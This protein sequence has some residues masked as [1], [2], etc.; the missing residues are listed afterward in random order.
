[1]PLVQIDWFPGRTEDQRRALAEAITKEVSRIGQ[2][3]PE[4]VDIIFRE[5]APGHWAHNGSLHSE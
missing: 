5:V 4:A 3:A 1:M 2:C